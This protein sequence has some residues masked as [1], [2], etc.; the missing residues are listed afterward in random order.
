MIMST[1]LDYDGFCSRCGDELLTEEIVPEK[2]N[3]CSCCEQMRSEALQVYAEKLK[4]LTRNANKTN[5]L[6]F[7]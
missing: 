2:E 5:E 4:S 7:S 3:L 1:V 6:E